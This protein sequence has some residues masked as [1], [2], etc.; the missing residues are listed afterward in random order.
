MEIANQCV[1]CKGKEIKRKRATVVPFLTNRIFGRN[2]FRT[3]LIYCKTCGF[4]FYAV[5]FNE[6][7]LVRLYNNYR[8]D[9]YIRQRNKYEPWYTRRLNDGLFARTETLLNRKKSLL[10]LTE[11]YCLGFSDQ[12]GTVLD[13]GGDKGQLLDGVFNQSKK[14][15]YE[16]S[17]VELLP[18]IN[19]A[20]FPSPDTFDFIICSNVLEHV[21]YPAETI[22]MIWDMAHENSI[23]Y[24]EVP[25]EQP[26]SV[27]TIVKRI[28]QQSMLLIFRPLQFIET[29]GLGMLTHMHEHVNYFSVKSLQILIENAGFKN[30]DI[31]VRSICNSRYFCCFAKK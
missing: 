15:V 14:F 25:F 22:K 27:S 31:S 13:F 9:E 12:I 28:V 10:E 8:D 16:I 18:G 4:Q 20:F 7:E 21:S 24:L 11:N 2:S 29:F 23:V 1:I 3:S 30:V 19:R 5:R 6:N 26:Y 17:N